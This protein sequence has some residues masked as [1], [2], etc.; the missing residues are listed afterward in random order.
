L[1]FALS[2][3]PATFVRESN[4]PRQKEDGMTV[5]LAEFPEWRHS[6][7]ARLGRLEVVSDKH[8]ENGN[9]H[10][11]LLG[12][13]D[14]DLSSIQVEFRAQRGLLQALHLTQ[15]QHSAAL[16]KLETGQ[17]ELRL[18]QAELRLGQAELRREMTEVRG[19]IRTII[20]LLDPADGTAK[21]GGTTPNQSAPAG[22][23]RGGPAG[24]MSWLARRVFQ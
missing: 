7:E 6:V 22:K 14:T 21:S 17:E 3:I 10:A 20:A 15:N 13:M 1:Q 9:H 11:G 12:S 4:G 24:S 2:G 8:V 19:G 5:E 23:Q 18:G 16:R